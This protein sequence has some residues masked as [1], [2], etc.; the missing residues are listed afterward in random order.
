MADEILQ[1]SD[2]TAD[3]DEF[4]DQFN[5]FLRTRP[6]WKG[7]LTTMTSQTLIDLVSAV[8]AHAQA[9]L[10]RASEDSFAET[11]QSDDAIRAITQMQGLRLTRKN[12]AVIP[13][14][15]NSAQDVTIPPYTQFTV[16]GQYYFNR[17]QL[18]IVA[19]VPEAVELYQGQLVVYQVGMVGT[20][21]QTFLSDE[22]GFNVSDTDTVVRVNGNI[23]EQSRGGLWNYRNL[24]AYS[25]LTLADGK[26]LVQ[27]GNETFGSMPG[28]N[29][30]VLISYALTEGDSGNNKNLKDKK[31]N[32]DGFP[33]ISGIVTADPTGGS[34]EKPIV[35][36]KNVASG[37]FGTYQSA[38]TRA[39]YIAMVSTYPGIIDAITQAQREIDPMDLKWMNVIRVSAL[40]NS[41]WTQSMIADFIEYMEK[42]TMYSTRF[43]W[44]DPIPVDRDLS[45]NVYCYN[46]AV[47]SQ[48]KQI[49]ET[50]ITQLF[51][52]KPGILLTDFFESD[53]TSTIKTATTGQ[54]S[55]VDVISPTVAMTVSPPQAVRPEVTPVPGGGVLGPQVY[56]YSIAVE[57]ADEIGP[58]N[59]WVFPQ[60]KGTLAN[61]ALSLTWKTVPNA[62]R[63][64]IYGRNSQQGYGLIVTLAAVP[65]VDTMTYVDTGAITP[66]GPLPPTISQAPIRYN[67]LRSLIIN[68]YYADRQQKMDGTPE[69]KSV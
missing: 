39:Q 24:P 29:D 15:L 68:V 4:K 16:G 28:V 27:F 40:T 17:D 66:V 56:G 49:S 32:I 22:D 33:L 13:A 10:M 59:K 38:V 54:V 63:Y 26:L 12:P 42:T 43:Y 58:P 46:T 55:H 47:L 20:P 57:T 8:G 37:S 53:L 64:H 41:P 7:T 45:I 69:R 51:A 18:P 14:T 30:T 11:A 67:R 1:L 36:Y 61:N 5:E 9:R 3:F 2:L 52:P 21:Y 25:D 6:V 23:I 65:N 62:I 48:I 34:D 50:A 31:V 19:N 44:Q 35:V 60:L